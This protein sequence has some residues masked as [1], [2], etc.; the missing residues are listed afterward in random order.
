MERLKVWRKLNQRRSTKRI[1][2]KS[3]STR[4]SPTTTEETAW[5]MQIL[6]RRRVFPICDQLPKFIFFFVVSAASFITHNYGKF[7]CWSPIC[8]CWSG[9]FGTHMFNVCCINC[10]SWLASGGN[11]WTQNWELCVQQ[12]IQFIMRTRTF[13]SSCPPACNFLFIIHSDVVT[14]I[15]TQPTSKRRRERGANGKGVE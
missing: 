13:T 2:I 11:E 5:I 7:V 15:N 6:P 3:S 9:Q 8:Y 10:P 1:N 14:Q 12:G 4:S